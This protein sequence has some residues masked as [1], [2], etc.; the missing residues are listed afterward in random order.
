MYMCFKWYIINTNNKTPTFLTRSYF[1]GLATAEFVSSC[2]N[3]PGQQFRPVREQTAT[4]EGRAVSGMKQVVVS[5]L[6]I[7]FYLI[8]HREIGLL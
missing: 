4:S 5:A 3:I 7:K 2:F 6:S 8:V 1:V